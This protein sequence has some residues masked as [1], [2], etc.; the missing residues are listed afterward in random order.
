MVIPVYKSSAA[1]TTSDDKI[2]TFQLLAKVGITIPKTIFSPKTF[3]IDDAITND[4]LAQIMSSFSFPLVIKEAYGSFGE[5]VYLIHNKNELHKKVREIGERTFMCQE[6]NTSSY[7]KDI[8]LQVVGDKVVAAMKRTAKNDLRANVTS[9][10][11]MEPYKPT[12]EE[13]QL[14]VKASQLIGAD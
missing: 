12:I 10:G 11:T 2:K 4:Y 3:G 1:N 8:R 7:G 14:A 9:G 13:T 6:L 5:Q